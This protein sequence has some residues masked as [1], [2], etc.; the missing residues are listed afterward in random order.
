MRERRQRSY[1]P[2]R[3]QTA[4]RL[5]EDDNLRSRPESVFVLFAKEEDGNDSLGKLFQRKQTCSFSSNSAIK[6]L[7][8]Q[9]H[10]R[11]SRQLEVKSTPKM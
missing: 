11:A 7:D 9:A 1:S 10:G 6:W 3:S 4:G 2:A 5:G 8:E